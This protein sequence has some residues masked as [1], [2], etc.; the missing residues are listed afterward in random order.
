MITPENRS[1]FIDAVSQ[2]KPSNFD[3]IALKLFQFQAVQN[4]I[5]KQ[6]LQLLAIDVNTIKKVEEIPFMPISF[7]K[8]HD[9]KSGNWEKE[10][11]FTSSGTTGMTTSKHPVKDLSW[12]TNNCRS[13]FAEVYGPPKDYCFLALL[14]AYLEREGSSLIYM[15]DDFIQQSKYSESGFFLNDIDEL[16]EVL[17]VCI[18][19]NIPTVL[20]G[21]SFA[22]WDL[23]EQN[24][25][26]L[27]NVIIMETGGMKGRRK[28]ITR[29]QL[30]QI[31]KKAF[32]VE[33]IHS[34]Y[35]MTELLSQAYS[36]GN[37]IFKPSNTMKVSTR[38]INDPFAQGEL[39][40]TGL[41]NIIDLANIDSC[42]FIATDDLG[43]VFSNGTFEITGRLDASDIRGCNLLIDTY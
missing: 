5:Y 42:A 8:S 17:S 22:L 33:N 28:E 30:H 40:K 4:P 9:I 39:T 3:E 23:A 7:F 6:F 35:G 37:G 31:F 38:E 27:K 2:V 41:I 34:E 24:P 36:T 11:I 43:K 25:R 15:V 10:V 20:L 12:Y 13:N 1:F 26:D 29:N 19:K 21:V 18:D 32:K 14:P 16:L